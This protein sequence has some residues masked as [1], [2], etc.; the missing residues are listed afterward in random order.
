MVMV[1]NIRNTNS[2]KNMFSTAYRIQT[3]LTLGF[4]VERKMVNFGKKSIS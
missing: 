1:H 3:L 4:L 2:K